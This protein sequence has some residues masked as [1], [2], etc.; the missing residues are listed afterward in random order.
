LELAKILSQGLAGRCW[1]S[2]GKL[3]V[4]EASSE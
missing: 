1:K 4:V 3:K 2:S